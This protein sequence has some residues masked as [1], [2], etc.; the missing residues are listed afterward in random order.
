MATA[1]LSHD[2]IMQVERKQKPAG[3]NEFSLRAVLC[4]ML[5]ALLMGASYPYIVLKLGFGPNISIVAAFLGYI[6]IVTIGRATSYN[7]WENNI[8]QTAGTSAGQTAFMCVLLAAFD[9]LNR[10]PDLGFHFDISPLQS[11][12]W[13]TVA[14]FMGVLLAV[15]F[16]RYFIEEEK[17]PYPDGIAVAETLTIL[18]SDSKSARASARSMLVSGVA[19]G[20]LTWLRDASKVIGEG[21]FWGPMG[22]K[23][24]LG[25]GWSL[26]SLGAGMIVGMRVCLSMGLGMMISWVILPQYLL[27]HGMI[28]EIAFK[29]MTRWVMWPATGLLVSAGLTSLFVRWRS[30][31]NS[32]KVLTAKKSAADTDDFPIRWVVI[33]VL[34]LGTLLCVI[35]KNNFNIPAW[36][37]L[38]SI[39]F[40]LPMMLVGLRVLGETNWGPISA[41]SNAIQAVFAMISPGNV[42]VNMMASGMTGT[43]A[44]ESEAIMQDYKAAH[45]IGSSNKYMTYAQ[46]MAVPIGALAVSF[47]Y[48]MLRNQY[49]IGVEGGLSAPIA[50]KW[51]GF[52]IL[53][54]KGLSALPPGCLTA[55]WISIVLGVVMTL[56]EAK[57]KKYIP[58]PTG[59]GIGML[60]PGIAISMMVLGGILEWVWRKMSPQTAKG[61]M[62]PVASGFIAGE[63]LLAIIMPI[64]VLLGW[65][66]L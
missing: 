32:F 39:L 25:L 28:T 8:V 64:L 61:H 1:E 29:M 7:R 31:M 41:M 59:V 52:A 38:L 13:L 42:P 20:A 34:V 30:L 60:V 6:V 45:L 47:T 46:L 10:E 15:P 55:F 66:K 19:A 23:L 17:L 4:G 18:D 50:V 2:D 5:V 56:L 3:L 57:W 65:L 11:A 16:R 53:L 40:S 24:N 48:V 43:I 21:W 33:G 26:L 49:G 22:H 36:I 62:I 37:T 9:L 14:G 27:D 63:A 44:V 12:L 54:T 58:S 51:S 35:Q